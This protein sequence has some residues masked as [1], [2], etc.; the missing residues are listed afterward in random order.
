MGLR[1]DGDKNDD[2]NKNQFDSEDS[3]G[4]KEALK[5]KTLWLLTGALTVAG[6]CVSSVVI[7]EFSLI[8]DRGFSATTAAAVLST[9][10]LMASVGRLF[11]G[12]IVEK[13]KV[14]YAMS[15]VFLICGLSLIM[16]VTVPS[17]PLLFVFAVIYGLSIGGYSVTT[18]VAFANY[19]G[20]ANVGSIRGAVSPLITGSVAVG[21]VLI[22]AGYDLQG[23]Y[24]V[25][26][27]TLTL[28]YLIASGLTL[29]AKPPQRA[30][31]TTSA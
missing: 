26:F 31:I 23:T 1:P 17:S 8:T 30:T 25:G 9:H 3:W 12:F 11:W 20:R 15:T 28:L 6:L 10:A 24:T 29:L 5:D 27:F 2:T 13:M 19:Y 16:L 21:P 22:A 14:R 7:H 4:L 18:A